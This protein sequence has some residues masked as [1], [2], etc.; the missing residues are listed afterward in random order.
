MATVCNGSCFWNQ[1]K[2]IKNGLKYKLG[3]KRCTFCGVFFDVKG[4]R[5]PCCSS[6]LRTKARTGN[7]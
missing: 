7:N 2:G 3:F 6:M 4:H 5:C 1:V